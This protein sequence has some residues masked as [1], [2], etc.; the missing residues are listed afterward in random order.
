MRIQKNSLF[1]VAGKQHFIW[2]ERYLIVEDFVQ[3]SKLL[4]NGNVNSLNL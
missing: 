1:Q 3:S 2:L 4:E